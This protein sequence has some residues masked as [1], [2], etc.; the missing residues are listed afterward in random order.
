MP[1]IDTGTAAA[2]MPAEENLMS[3]L[4][5]VA[6]GGVTLANRIVVL[7]MCQYSVVEGSAADWHAQHLGSHAGRKASAK[8]PW[9]GAGSSALPFD[10]GWPAP[11]APD[12]ADLTR[13]LE[14]FA[15][16]A[17]RADRPC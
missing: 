2:L 13:I 16:A 14:A 15:A 7:L 6:I 12:K 9:Q 4:H 11:H 10:A 1:G 8:L 5:T 17:Q 3:H